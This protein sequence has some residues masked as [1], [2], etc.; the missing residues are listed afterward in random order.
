[1]QRLIA[2]FHRVRRWLLARVARRVMPWSLRG[3]ATPMKV[4]CL[5]RVVLPGLAARR[6]PV[7]HEVRPGVVFRGNS[8]DFV[9]LCVHVFGRWEPAMTSF[10][11]SRLA[12]GRV[13][14]DVGANIGWFDL[15]AAPLVEPGGSVVAVEASPAIH[16]R[17]TEQLE[18]NGIR[19]VRAVN[20]AVG[21][22]AGWVHIVDGPSWNSAQTAVVADVERRPGS[23]V[24]RPLDEIL[25]P[26][27]I[28]ACRVVKIDVEGAEFEVVRGLGPL[29][30]R[31]PGDAEIV[32]EVG[33][34]RAGAAAS[35]AELWDT[36]VSRGFCAYE[37]PNEYTVRFLRD[38]VV[39]RALRRL[40]APPATQTD[41]VF[42]RVRA[43]ELAV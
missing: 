21:A 16:A 14:V 13:F 37:L 29:F 7:E 11:T 17:L 43:D 19:N 8:A 2:V 20:E 24:C 41:V 22:S 23:V 34:G 35:V 31:L 28:A 42:S 25:T 33:P 10:L 38:P 5:R 15:L 40:H 32:V 1:M 26:D 9:P 3:S 27:E 12:P 36:F 4:L 30:D 18:R 39:P 6:E